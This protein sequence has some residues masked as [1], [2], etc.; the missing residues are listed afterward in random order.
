MT[1][2]ACI[3]QSGLTIK[4]VALHGALGHDMVVAESVCPVCRMR[5]DLDTIGCCT[6]NTAACSIPSL[7]VHWWFKQPCHTASGLTK[8]SMGYTMTCSAKPGGKASLKFFVA[9]ITIPDP[10]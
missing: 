6:R 7:A 5:P 1:S 3:V 9:C 10:S 8:S 2:R 4:H